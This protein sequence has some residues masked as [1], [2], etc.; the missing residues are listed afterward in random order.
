MNEAQSDH[1]EATVQ[2]MAELHGEHENSATPL[3]KVFESATS[4]LGRPIALIS[5]TAL[6][7]VWIGYNLI[8]KRVGWWV[9]D[10]PPF[11]YLELATSL[12]ALAATVLILTSQRRDDIA[13]RHRSQLTLNIATLSEHKI[14]K[15]I[16]L[17]EEQRR[18]D[19]S[20]PNREDQQADELARPTDPKQV[21]ERI[22][23]THSAAEE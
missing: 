22:K 20:L 2:Q 12:G 10:P 3:Q 18:Q 11:G 9:P 23:D 5:L 16:G 1:V 15:V 21:L 17:L 7:A 6:A 14:A 8:A 13:A 19:P 4:S